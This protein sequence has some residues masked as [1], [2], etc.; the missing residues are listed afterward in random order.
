MKHTCTCAVHC[1][2]SPHHERACCEVACEC[3][4]HSVKSQRRQLAISQA[5]KEQGEACERTYVEHCRACAEY[6]IAPSDFGS[7]FA[8]W[9]ECER[10][11]DRFAVKT[12]DVEQLNY[13]GRIRSYEA[14]FDGLKGY[15]AA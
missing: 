4:C 3:W 14:L 1:Q 2:R 15:E 11:E 8:E 5:T 13:D 7:F 6:S 9:L 12:T 10:G